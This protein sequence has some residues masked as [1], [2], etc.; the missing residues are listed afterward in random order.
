MEK[1]LRGFE[2]LFLHIFLHHKMTAHNQLI[3]VQ[4]TLSL[5]LALKTGA[6]DFSSMLFLLQ[7]KQQAS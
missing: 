6:M 2:G 1:L 3:S 7:H 4:S 5:M